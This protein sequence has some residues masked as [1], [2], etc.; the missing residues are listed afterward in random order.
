MDGQLGLWEELEDTDGKV[1]SQKYANP[2]TTICC[3][4]IRRRKY[5]TVLTGN[6]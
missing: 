1:S 5:E 6:A 4:E 3:Y 2:S